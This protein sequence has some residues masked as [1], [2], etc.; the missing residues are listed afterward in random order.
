MRELLF[1]RLVQ[2]T[3]R[4]LRNLRR[5]GFHGSLIGGLL[6]IIRSMRK[7]AGHRLSRRPSALAPRC[8]L[9]P[10]Q[11]LL[12]EGFKLLRRQLALPDDDPRRHRVLLLPAAL[13][14]I[15]RLRLLPF[16]LAANFREHVEIIRRISLLFII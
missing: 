6:Q 12:L 5:S 1:L 7:G 10:I 13:I 4:P 8:R 16:N 9:T 15:S 3:L 14:R 11:H 2:R